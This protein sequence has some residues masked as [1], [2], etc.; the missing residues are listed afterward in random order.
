MLV[1]HTDNTPRLFPYFRALNC[2]FIVAKGVLHEANRETR[3]TSRINAPAAALAPL[4]LTSAPSAGRILT[5]TGSLSMELESRNAT[6][7]CSLAQSSDAI[8]GTA[9]FP[10]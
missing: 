9:E 5:S 4:Y 8:L 1:C 7:S 10:F 2:A 6:F 3:E